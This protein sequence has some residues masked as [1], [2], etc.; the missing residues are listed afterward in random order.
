MPTLVVI[1][2]NHDTPRLPGTG[3]PYS[4]LADTF[5]EAALRH[6][7]QYER[8]DLPRAAWCTPCP[9]CTGRPALEARIAAADERRSGDHRNLLLTHPP[10]PQVQP[11]PYADINEIEVDAGHLDAEFDLVLL[12]HFHA[13][14]RVAANIWYP[15]STDSFCF[16]DCPRRPQAKGIAQPRHRPRATSATTP[17]PGGGPC[18]RST[19]C[20]PSAWRPPRSRGRRRPGRAVGARGRRRPAL[21]R[22]RRPRGLPPARPAASR[23]RRLRRRPGLHLKL[24]PTCDEQAAQL[25]DLPVTSLARPVGP[26]PGEQDPTGLR[27]RPHQADWAAYLAPAVEEEAA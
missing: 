17:S 9:R 10:V 3:S 18:S 25:A 20:T 23:P 6:R 14:P 11:L 22:R 21:H 16:A 13:S 12:G 2:G 15:G 7:L 19:P 27:P 24:E 5:P 4:V 1:S 8:F 26:L